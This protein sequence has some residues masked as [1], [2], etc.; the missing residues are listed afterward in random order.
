MEHG[1][2][3]KR[4]INAVIFLMV[5]AITVLLGIEIKQINE[6][7]PQV[8]FVNVERNAVAEVQ[9]GVNM[10]IVDASM[11]SIEE[12]EVRYGDNFVE[13]IGQ[14]YSYRTIEVTVRLE[15]KSDEAQGMALYELYLEQEDYCNG[16]APE[17]FF[18]IGNETDYVTIEAGGEL[19]VTLGYLIYKKQFRVNEWDS[20]VVED[21]WIARQRYP[22]KIKW[23]I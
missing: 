2:N 11:F 4:V 13:E 1:N 15:N 8:Q 22:E 10:S 18:E 9:P 16:L 23:K 5:A 19:E 3:K 12:A 20:M 6:V 7:Y 14:N 21:F 17:V